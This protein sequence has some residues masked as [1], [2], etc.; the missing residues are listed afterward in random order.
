MKRQLTELE[1]AYLCGWQAG[2][3]TPWG[4]SEAIPLAVFRAW[5]PFEGTWE[6]GQIVQITS[7][8]LGTWIA[9]GFYRGPELGEEPIA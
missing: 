4:R 5:G 2:R 8:S 9:N 6:N 3:A 7:P 1:V